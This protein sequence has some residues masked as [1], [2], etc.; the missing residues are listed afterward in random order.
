MEKL[1]IH[2]E[3]IHN[4]NA[5]EI[6]V[7]LIMQMMP[8]TSVLDVGC[9]TGTWLKVFNQ[10]FGLTDL[11]GVDG[12]YV[13]RN[14]LVI[15]PKFFHEADLR[16]S[17]D[18]K[19]KFDI[20]LCLEVAEHLPED[21]ADQFVETLCRHSDRI[22]FS[23]AIPGQGGQMHINE[24]WPGYWSQKFAKHGYNVYDD[25]RPKI[26][27][28]GQVDI[29]YRQNIFHFRRGQYLQQPHFH[30]LAEVHPEYWERK[31]KSIREKDE[32]INAFDKGRAGVMRSFKALVK[33]INN[34]F[35]N[36]SK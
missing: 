14:Q 22:I 5:A 11:I 30:I 7:P 18:L 8:S 4:T 15:D 21:C 33:A 3:S 29:W 1:Y 17:I 10:K 25:I 2:R 13:D 35:F 6:V 26:W 34:K 27:H 36:N 20:V 19:R 9:G 31:I 16:K 32:Q 23:A 12:N 24:Q 28:N